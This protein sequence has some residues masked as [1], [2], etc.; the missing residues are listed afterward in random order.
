[1][2]LLTAIVVSVIIDGR[3]IEGIQPATLVRGTVVAPLE[4]YFD[5]FADRIVRNAD[6]SVEVD[7]G[8]HEIVI[9]PGSAEVRVDSV[10]RRLLI[11]PYLREGRI[12]VPLA[13]IARALGANVQFNG[14]QKVLSI[15]APASAPIATMTPYVAPLT[16]VSP[17]P[18][19][20]PTPAP[21]PQS[22]VTGIPQPRRTPLAADPPRLPS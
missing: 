9:T 18:T 6:G 2:A 14:T 10:R 12:I 4:P 11:A 21:A 16:R 22:T 5:R 17:G 15:D 1:M 8:A 19:F 7:R 3:S 13:A 20:T